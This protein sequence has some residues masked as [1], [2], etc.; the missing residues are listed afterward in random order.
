M[1]KWQRCGQERVQVYKV[2]NLHCI[3]SVKL[4]Y[5]TISKILVYQLKKFFTNSV[6]LAQFHN[7]ISL[8]FVKLILVHNMSVLIG[9]I[10]V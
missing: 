2:D 4:N 9:Y 1:C 3:K 5:F 7:N 8:K 10:L 6:I